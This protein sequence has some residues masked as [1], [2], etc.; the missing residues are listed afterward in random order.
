M[1]RM[2][3]YCRRLRGALRYWLFGYPWRVSWD[4][5]RRPS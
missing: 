3:H 5:A 1:R 4:K 2:T